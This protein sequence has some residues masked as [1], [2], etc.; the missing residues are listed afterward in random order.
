[1]ADGVVRAVEGGRV[2]V[3]LDG[4]VVFSGQPYTLHRVY[5]RVDADGVEGLFRE[6]LLGTV[7]LVLLEVGDG[8]R[9]VFLLESPGDV[10]HV[11]QGELQVLALL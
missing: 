10:C 2:H 4:L 3:A 1:M 6:D 9:R 5:R 8:R 7:L 11:G